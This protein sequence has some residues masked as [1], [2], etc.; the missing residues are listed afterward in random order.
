[1]GSATPK[2][3]SPIPIPALNSIASHAPVLNS[4]R[5]SSLPSRI[6]PKRL[7]ARKNKKTMN[8][9]V[10]IKYTQP[11][12]SVTIARAAVL[13]ASRLPEK[14]TPQTTNRTAIKTET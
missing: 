9:V 6:L 4:G 11:K 12:D 10:A 8:R 14:N 3:T 2:K 1:M 5:S 13:K 7:K